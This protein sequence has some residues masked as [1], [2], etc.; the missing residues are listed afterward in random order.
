MSIPG[1]APIIEQQLAAARQ[2]LQAGRLEEAERAYRA[3][4]Q[5]APRNPKALHL[6]GAVRM[7]RGDAAEAV[8]WL[9][10]S[11]AQWP[12]NPYAWYHLALAQQRLGRA[13]EA[14]ASYQRAAELYPG[15]FAGIHNN[16]GALWQELGDLE[17]ARAAYARALALQPD[18]ARA[19]CNLGSVL[20]AQG[21]RAEGVAA[22][23]RALQHDPRLFDAWFN[24][25]QVLRE[26]G[27]A[28]G[29]VAALEEA[30]RCQPEAEQARLQLG[31]ALRERGDLAAA[32]AAYRQILERSPA[33]VEARIGLGRLQAERC[34][35]AAAESSFRQV[36]S[37]DPASLA[38]LVGLVD[39]YRGRGEHE[40]ALQL[41][42]EGLQRAPGAPALLLSL[43]N[44]YQDRWQ[45][46]PAAA[47]YRQAVE[48]NP[49][50]AEAW[51]NL[52]ASLRELKRHDE[53]LAAVRRAL[54]LRPGSANAYNNLANIHL[55]LKQWQ[56]AE[57][58][59]RQ[60]LR[61]APGFREALVNLAV[62][63][64]ERKELQAAI[65]L[66]EQALERDP[67]CAEAV[68]QLYALAQRL[69]DWPRCRRYEERLESLTRQALEQGGR[70]AEMPLNHLR[71]VADPQRNLA[72]ARAWSRMLERQGA[73]QG[74]PFTFAD[75]RRPRERLRIGYLSAD[76]RN[77]A[78]GHLL[79]GL[80]E[81]HDRRRFEVLAYS[82]GEDDGSATRARIVQAADRFVDIGRLGARDGA[83]RIY[84]DEVDILVDLTGY[85][86]DGRLDICAL[87]PAPV[88]VSYLGF[89]G[90]SGADFLDY[91]ITDRIL[92]PEDQAGCYSE[93]FVYLPE[94]YQI[95]D[96]RQPIAAQPYRRADFALPETGIVFGAFNNAYK[97][98]PELFALWLRILRRV[99]DSVLWLWA[100]DPGVEAN[101][102]REAAAAG[103]EPARLVFAR[104][105]PIEQHLA[106]LPLADLIL[107]TVRYSGGATTSNCLWAGVPVLTMLG[108]RYVSR[109]SASLLHA[110]GLP[111]LVVDSLADYE[112][113]AVRLA[114]RPAERR[115][116][117]ERLTRHRATAALFDTVRG[118]RHLEAA[119]EAMWRSFLAGEPPRP[120]AVAPL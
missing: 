40:R 27:D 73:A 37:L 30:L 83:E 33:A 17:Q 98:D 86:S 101:L 64:T 61:L 6:L 8:S 49:D 56:S 117:R 60:A 118:V 38:G 104:S 10:R 65:D 25:G 20:V 19:H 18:Y 74:A 81:Q 57:E 116:L 36:L 95:N 113:T 63:L 70:P 84:R 12:D 106:R 109:M 51:N 80:F 35:W 48:R 50:L 112:E 24:L 111:E 22:Y 88:Q 62:V 92:T 41:V 115:A 67:A 45:W 58:A 42:Q 31:H 94:C 93:K 3:I 5:Q 26:D 100:S 43:G 55:S 110:V 2:L 96:D 47:A 108:N 16:L 44:V 75:R 97:I 89:P 28:A 85:T 15:D 9:E 14:I 59:Y 69:C 103:I 54:E 68:A 66:L 72:V 52:A 71:R 114:C 107:D 53:A 77:H 91:V 32:E 29:A 23:R 7:E 1:D 39:V 120:I 46:Q 105:L 119:F 11:L 79:P 34:D 21:R 13:R 78:V 87:R 82:C 4:L 76:F 90:S 102:S 99:P